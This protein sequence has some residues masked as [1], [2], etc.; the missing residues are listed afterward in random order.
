MRTR[1]RSITRRVEDLE[2]GLARRTICRTCLGRPLRL[3]G[4]D[5]ETDEVTSETFPDTGCPDCGAP[6]AVDLLL[7]D[8]DV[9]RV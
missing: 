2:E 7:V 8:V 6:I 1:S 9:A 4:I 5:P 3:V